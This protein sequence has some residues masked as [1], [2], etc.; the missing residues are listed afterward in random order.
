MT[1]LYMLEAGTSGAHKEISEQFRAGYYFNAFDQAMTALIDYPDDIGLKHVAV[2][3]LLRGGTLKAAEELFN[4]FNLQDESHEDILAL[5]GRLVKGQ[6][7]ALGQKA[8]L[9]LYA[10]AAVLYEKTYELARGS[11]SGVNAA[12]LWYK[13]GDKARAEKIATE[14][15]QDDAIAETQNNQSEYYRYATRAECLYILGEE[16][17]AQ[18]ALKKALSFDPDNYG[19]RA[20]TL[21][22][23]EMLGGGV[24]PTCAAQLKV[25]RTLHYTGHLFHIG[26][27]RL[28][29]SLT[30]DEA[31]TLANDIRARLTRHP[32]SSAYGAL[33][34]GVDILFAEI[35]LELGVDLHVV[36]PVPVEDFKRLS[37]TPMGAYWEPR[38]EA[39]LARAKSVRVILQDPGDFD[40][41]DL[42]M[43]SLIAMGL[44]RLTAQHLRTDPMQ[45]S[46]MDKQS[47][48]VA[49]A[50]T[51]YDIKVW[52]EAGGTTENIDWPHARQVK[53]DVQL[54]APDRR[55]FRAMLFTDLKG[56][57]QLPDRALPDIV[58][59]I[60]EPMAK[61][62]QTLEQ[63]PLDI[64]TWG[65][66][67]F[68][69]FETPLA[70]ARAAFEI[71]EGF[72][73]SVATTSGIKGRELALRVGVHFGPVWER[74]D[75]FTQ[76]PNLY[77]RH[78]TTA[79]RLE[80]LAVPGSICVSENFAAVMAM[81]PMEDN[82][83]FSCDYVGRATSQKEETEFP[84]YSLRKTAG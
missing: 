8:G 39:A 57:G 60:F 20:S 36:L 12:S 49:L 25:P 23:F 53:P 51:R 14:I 18:A 37:V 35:L 67:L 63:P 26:P 59:D 4:G 66:G 71:M 32:I 3:S 40:N 43:G 13:A 5:S 62:C 82:Q 6:I 55:L 31:K 81:T 16:Q 84:L 44:A 78:V 76:T 64:K 22:Q 47:S 15:L 10:K 72:K 74:L 33:A 69:V 70:A 73:Q 61:K 7:E 21:R 2:L 27:L 56:Y 54:P 68:L 50:G 42:K 52:H 11:Y 46:V 58:T 77:G 9:D 29:R 19:A 1:R 34:A 79:A 28:E 17:G 48:D 38:F 83:E 45:M 65:D 30:H 41:L 75:P 24:I 80:A